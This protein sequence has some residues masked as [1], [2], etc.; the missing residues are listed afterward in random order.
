MTRVRIILISCAILAIFYGGYKLGTESTKSQVANAKLE[1]ESVRRKAAQDAEAV[2]KAHLSELAALD[3]KRTAAEKKLQDAGVNHAK[4]LTTARTDAANLRL[5][6]AGLRVCPALQAHSGEASEAAS[7][8]SGASAAGEHD[9]S[10][11]ENLGSYAEECEGLR[12]RAIL[13]KEYA[14]AIQ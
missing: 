4:S 9:S 7:A 5:S 10:L 6:L 1:T 12:Q 3:V 11:A 8:P 2:A 14:E 13:S